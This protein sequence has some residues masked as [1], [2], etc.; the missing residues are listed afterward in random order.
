MTMR[1]VYLLLSCAATK[2]AS[3]DS[4][5]NSCID[6]TEN[7]CGWVGNLSNGKC[8]AASEAFTLVFDDECPVRD[9]QSI[10]PGSE[11]EPF[12]ASWMRRLFSIPEASLLTVLDI[13]LPGSHDSLSYDLSLKVSDGGIDSH[14]ALAAL[15]HEASSLI[16]RSLEDYMREQGATQGLTVS[17]Q[18]DSGVRFLDL[19]V[20]YEYTDSKREW[21]SL[22]FIQSNQAFVSYLEQIRHWLDMH[23][24]E[25]VVLWISKHGDACAVGQD[26]Y[27][28]TPIAEKVKFW[29]QIEAVFAGLLF[30]GNTSS[31]SDTPVVKLLEQNQRVIIMAADWAEF[32]NSSSNALDSCRTI[33]N[34]LGPSVDNEIAAKEWETGLFSSFAPSSVTR[35]KAKAEQRFL[36]M[37]L[38]TGVPGAQMTLAA[39]IKY[40]PGHSHELSEKCAAA[41]NIPGFAYCPETLLDI[42][43]LE[44]YYKQLTLEDVVQHSVLQLPASQG[45]TT[46]GFPNAIYINAID[47]DGTIRTG[48]QVLWGKN[49]SSDASHAVSAYAYADSIVLYNVFLACAG[50]K[51]QACEDL[52]ESLMLRRSRHPKLLWDDEVFGRKTNWSGVI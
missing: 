34:M 51:S 46:W 49:R 36:L 43:S 19:R 14:A 12:L 4:F 16:P 17:Q 9:V 38:A 33:T 29:T 45:N 50:S 48:T 30:N 37:S 15:L 13:S 40:L 2:A 23:P 5:S 20:M 31:I 42:A 18:L 10:D 52:Q 25:I 22:H 26:Q 24:R 6:C 21:L 39:V 35:Q 47:F 7:K 41:F 3:C 1:V 44:N 27:P 28:N 32:T 11:G 8:V